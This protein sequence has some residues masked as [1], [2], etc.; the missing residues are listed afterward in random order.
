M[1]GPTCMHVAST[2]S[3]GHRFLEHCRLH[4]GTVV[5]APQARTHAAPL[6]PPPPP[7][8]LP[9]RRSVPQLASE[10]GINL[11]KHISNGHWWHHQCSLLLWKILATSVANVGSARC[12]YA[13]DWWCQL[14]PQGHCSEKEPTYA[15][16][17]SERSIITT[18]DKNMTTVSVICPKS[19][20]LQR[21]SDDFQ[22]WKSNKA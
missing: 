10:V 21:T 14:W 11:Q 5:G 8:P 9:T 7:E 3:S 2:I 17:Y 16:D 12:Y 6:Q 15:H 18:F 1:G 4:G 13:S 19:F 20:T 22:N